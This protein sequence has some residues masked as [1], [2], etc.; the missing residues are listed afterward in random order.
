MRAI[1]S[2]IEDFLRDL[3]YE[4]PERK[5]IVK[6]VVTARAFRGEEPVKRLL[7]AEKQPKR[8]VG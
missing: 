3:L 6:Y 1:R 7:R 8:E 5:D 2:L 4:L